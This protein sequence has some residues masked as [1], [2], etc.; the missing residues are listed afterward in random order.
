MKTHSSYHDHTT[1]GFKLAFFL[2]VVGALLLAVKI[3]LFP[4]E[5]SAI[6]IS[7]QMAIILIGLYKFFRGKF[8]TSAILISIGAFFIVPKIA[9]L[10]NSFI[11]NLPEFYFATYW[12]VLLILGGI[13][14][15]A[16]KIQ[17]RSKYSHNDFFSST[18]THGPEE[19]T[20]GYFYKNSSF[21]SSEHIILDPLFKG[22][23]VVSSFGE[24]T[25]DLRKTD[26]AEGETVLNLNISFAEFTLYVPENWNV[27]VVLKT[28]FCEFKDKRHAMYDVS[29]SDKKLIITG[30]ISF[31]GGEIRN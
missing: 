7:W 14:I 4:S 2:I 1:D 24:L 12:P 26:I 29:K 15:V 20:E 8:L 23:E 17:S 9:Q 25:L 16:H 21:Q 10:P 3:G 27:Q 13:F 28:S 6:I 19:H 30:K 22:G 5:Y 18:R 11:Q 31:A